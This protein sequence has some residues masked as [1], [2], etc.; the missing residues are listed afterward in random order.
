VARCRAGSE[1]DTRSGHFAALEDASKRLSAQCKA[2]REKTLEDIAWQ[3][4]PPA[5]ARA[6]LDTLAWADRTL[7]H[8]WRLAE[9]LR[10][11]SGQ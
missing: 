9:S 1:R 5:T 2:G 11:A 8:A 3:R 10:D 4:V 7:Y 6:T